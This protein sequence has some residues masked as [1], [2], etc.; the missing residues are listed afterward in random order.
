[1]SETHVSK[2][3]RLLGILSFF[4][5]IAV[6]ALHLLLPDRDYSETEK[7]GLSLF[8]KITKDSL[9][10]GEAMSSLDSYAADQFPERSLLMKIRMNLSMF[11]GKRKSNGVFYAKDGTLIEKFEDYD[12]ELMRGTAEALNAFTKRHGFENCFLLLSPTAVSVY[13]EKLPAFAETGDEKAYISEFE[14]QLSP[15]FRILDTDEVYE[16]LTAEGEEIFYR[17]DHHWRTETAY[18]MFSA[19]AKEC[20]WKEAGFKPGIVTN[21]FSGSLASKSGF[22]PKQLDEITVYHN[23]TPGSDVLITHAS[24]DYDSFGSFYDYSRLG[25]SNP[26]ELFLGGNDPILIIQTTADSNRTLLV[27]KDSYANCFIPF[28]QE[29]YKT[30]CVID[31]RYTSDSLDHILSEAVYDDLLVLYNAN[32][33]SQDDNLRMI[34][35]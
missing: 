14:A 27:L 1:M 29:S 6:M 9:L 19:Y 25:S 33:L 24:E 20:G 13:P 8:P 16:E 35:E 3:Y 28:L 34:L 4:L 11:L 7:R 2:T 5:L 30:I 15:D 32:T 21:R 22:T 17:T 31:P 12:E 18:R 26:Y 10:D 23:E